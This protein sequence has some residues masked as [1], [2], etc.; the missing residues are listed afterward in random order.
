MPKVDKGRI[1][2]AVRELLLAIGENPDR[3]GLAGTP[4]RVARSWS[5][6]MDYDPGKTDTVF[7][8]STSADLVVVS[9]IRLWSFCEHHMLPFWCDAAIGYM[10]NGKQ[11]IGLSKI[12]RIAHKHSHK[13]QLQERIASGIAE[14][15][16][17][18]TGTFDVGVILRGEHLCMSM[19]GIRSP[20]LMTTSDMRGGFH[21][22]VDIRNDFYRLA[23][24]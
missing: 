9:G 7:N 22:D 1:E 2:I 20:G 10:P 16:I 17:D 13:L 11:V 21:N 24:I 14:E 4:D 12:A 5:E 6:F 15:M 8:E 23:G 18:V 3:E 19:R